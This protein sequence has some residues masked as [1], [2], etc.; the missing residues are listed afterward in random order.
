MNMEAERENDDD[1]QEEVR[2]KVSW[3]SMSSVS[4]RV[5]KA[6]SAAVV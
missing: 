2:R 5:W 4:G 1:S 6:G 3:T